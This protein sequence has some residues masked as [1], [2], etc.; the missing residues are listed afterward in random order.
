MKNKQKIGVLVLLLVVAVGSYFIAG[1]YARYSKSI[2]GGDIA[3]VAKFSVSATGFDNEQIANINLFDNIKEEDTITNESDVSPNRIAPGTGGKFS[4]T[5]K[6]DSEVRVL[7]KL[8]LSETNE[9]NIP[10]EYSLDGENWVQAD[11][12]TKEVEL[13]YNGSSQS[14]TSEDITIYWRWPF[15]SDDTKDTSLGMS[16]V[17]PTVTVQVG[18]IFTQ[19]N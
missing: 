3:S 5:L 11:K 15:E 19:I 9:S 7:A 2:T 8:T 12:L 18:I 1:A 6:N 17:S 16:D 10:I 13:D 14:K 4:T